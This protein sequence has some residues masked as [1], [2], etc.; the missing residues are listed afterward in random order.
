MNL[1]VVV[2]SESGASARDWYWV[3]TFGAIATMCMIAAALAKGFKAK[4]SIGPIRDT[5]AITGAPWIFGFGMG[6]GALG[7]FLLCLQ[8]VLSFWRS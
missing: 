2:L 5:L 4:K 6:T 8:M 3:V 7:L 1:L